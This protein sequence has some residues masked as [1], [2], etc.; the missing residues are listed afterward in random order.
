M[1]TNERRGQSQVSAPRT[2]GSVVL[3]WV[4]G[5]QGNPKI[6]IPGQVHYLGGN[7][8][9]HTRGGIEK[10]D[11]KGGA[12]LRGYVMVQVTVV[13]GAPPGDCRE[14]RECQGYPTEA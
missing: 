12:A 13:V 4:P 11:G 6:R 10:L 2:P 3:V 1:K 5:P 14:Q 8:R 9:K 7:A